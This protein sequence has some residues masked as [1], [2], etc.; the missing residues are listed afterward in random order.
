MKARSKNLGKT[1]IQ[2]HPMKSF[3]RDNSSDIATPN[4]IIRQAKTKLD[5]SQVFVKHDQDQTNDTKPLSFIERRKLEKEER[6]K[7]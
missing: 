6:Y 7:Q 4:A 1:R 5:K 2:A 3:D